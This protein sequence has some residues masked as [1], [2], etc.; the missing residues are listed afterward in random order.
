[1]TEATAACA[2]AG[3]ELPEALGLIAFAS[4]PGITLA[5]GGEWTKQI[6]VLGPPGQFT[7]AIVTTTATIDGADSTDKLRFRCVTPLLG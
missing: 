3:G 4:Q 7:M 5:A 1:M 2:A 6:V